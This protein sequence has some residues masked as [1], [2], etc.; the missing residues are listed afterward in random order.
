MKKI[1]NPH[2]R[3][4]S[5]EH[6]KKVDETAEEI[7]KRGLSFLKEFFLRLKD[8]KWR[9]A[10]I[11]AIDKDDNLKEIHQVGLTNKNGTPVA[12]E[13]RA[14]DDIEQSYNINVVF[15]KYTLL[16]ILTSLL[17]IKFILVL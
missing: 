11:V 15:H 7:E 14:I 16:F 3:K 10:D 17:A 1:P 9:Y 2:G 12:R 5:P 13:K 6:R 8:G 4:G